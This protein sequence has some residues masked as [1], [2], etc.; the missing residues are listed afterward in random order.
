M[1]ND[2]PAVAGADTKIE[3]NK[4][5]V[6]LGDQDLK[7]EVTF[8]QTTPAGHKVTLTAG[9]GGTL[10]CFL[11]NATEVQSGSTV[12]DGVALRFTA[13]P[14]K[15]YKTDQWTING[16]P[17]AKG[18]GRNTIIQRADK[19]LN[20]EV[21]FLKD[22]K[23]YTVEYVA[24]EGGTIAATVGA[25]AKAI[26]SKDQVEQG[27]VI[28]FT[29]TPKEG[30]ELDQWMVNDKPAV[31]GADTK[32]EG[33]KLIVTLGDQD[34]KVEATFKKVN[35]ISQISEAGLAVYPNPFAERIVITIPAECIGQTAYLTSMQGEVVLQMTLEQTETVLYTD[36]L[37]QGTYL[38][39]V[40][41]QS[42]LLI[43]E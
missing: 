2:K 38:L 43:K 6:T 7:V 1:V 24:G 14:M 40:G 21:S 4:L 12:D 22:I 11:S 28:T 25:E 19:D 20:V 35:A 39:R 16:E 31:A 5:I 13:K 17:F 30:Y 3:G 18:K 15:G 41:S 26:Q 23:L 32:I 10:Q 29:A 42:Q 34:L 36:A 9:E 33:N 27:A 37:S 8:K